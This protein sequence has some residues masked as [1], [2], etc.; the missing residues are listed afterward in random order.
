MKLQQLLSQTRQAIDTYDMIQ[1]GDKIAIGISGGKDSL[2]LLYALH[3]LR[4]FYPNSF[5]IVAIT[6]SLG[7]DDFDLSA[8]QTLCDSL[9]VPYHVVKTEISKIVFEN[10]DEKNP[11]SLCAKMRK[12]ALN[13]KALELGCN[14][15]ALGHHKED[16]IETFMLSLFYEGRLQTFLPSTYL[17]RTGLFSIRPL[18]F[19]SERDIIGFKNRHNLPVVSSPCPVDK[20]TKREDMKEL[21]SQLNYNIPGSKDR[22]FKAISEGILNGSHTNEPKHESHQ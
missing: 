20:K 9:D 13:E 14:K 11:C 16:V 18:I 7:F 5:E 4:R 12:G 22:M 21:L 10:R 17:D 3:G 2:A 15:I 19:V 6:I 1:T 8:V